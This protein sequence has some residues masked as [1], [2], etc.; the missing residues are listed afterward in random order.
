MNIS[1]LTLRDRK[2]I[3]VYLA[4]SIVHLAGSPWLQEEL[5]REN[6]SIWSHRQEEAI[7]YR[8]HIFCKLK[9]K[10]DTV[11][12]I[13]DHVAGLGVLILELAT[14]KIAG[15]TDED[16]DYQLKRKTN[17]Q[18][19][20]R[21]L[22]DEQW[23]GEIEEHYRGIGDACLAFNS[24]VEDFEHPDFTPE[25]TP[26]AVLYK[27]ILYPLYRLLVSSFGTTTY[28]FPGM[29][30]L[31]LPTQIRESHAQCLVMFDDF[32]TKNRDPG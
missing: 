20:V 23:R 6:L 5:G 17:I 31:T 28:L 21:I 3:G 14:N 9:Q 32:D 15:W 16:A 2:V 13:A 10:S 27:F 11:P 1:D 24:K 22:S 7:H 30:A 19:L 4:L 26:L 12:E 25:T 8:P 18:R 29:S